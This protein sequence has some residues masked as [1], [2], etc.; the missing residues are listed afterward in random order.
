MIQRGVITLLCTF[1]I[2]TSSS[3]KECIG[4]DGSTLT[5]EISLEEVSAYALL[6]SL[7]IQIAKLDTYIKRT[8]L[9]RQYS[10]FDTFLNASAGYVDDQTKQSSSFFGTRT[11][12]RTYSAGLEKKLP[13]GSDISF[14]ATEI[15]TWTDS[16][17]SIGNPLA[18]TSLGVSLTQA[19]GKNFFG[20]ADQAKIKITKID[21]ENAEYASLEDIEL[22]LRNVQIAYWTLVLKNE[23]LEIKQALLKEAQ[24][25]YSVYQENFK[26]GL[27]EEGD[28]FA[29]EANVQSRENDIIQARLQKETAKNNLLFLLNIND[30][31]LAVVPRESLN[32]SPWSVDFYEELNKAIAFRRD[33]KKIGN[34]LNSHEITVAVTKNALWP[35]IDL[36]VSYLRNG[37]DPNRSTS[38]D[39]VTDEDHEEVFFGLSFKTP[40]ERKKERAD[41]EGAK[42]KKEQIL[43]SLK[44][45]ERLILKDINVR[46]QEVNALK[47]QIELFASIEQLQRKKLNEEMI[48]LK[49]GRSNADR[50]IRYENDVLDAQLALARAYFAYRVSLIDLDLA[51]NTLLDQYWE[52]EL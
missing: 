4:A 49:Y 17:F 46:V 12:T 8:D 22:I 29:V 47:N 34:N 36:T 42:L 19:L 9:N 26:L 3:P 10:M 50:I 6:N 21:I 45:I 25:L 31:S 52:E 24:R 13:S 20:L 7:D 15:R 18:E 40:L 14:T 16:S 28:L 33:Y 35:E 37:L 41:I 32:I 5:K 43:L 1:A 38:W 2:F 51:K 27:V 30:I 44:R 23:E 48:R 11:N 39:Q